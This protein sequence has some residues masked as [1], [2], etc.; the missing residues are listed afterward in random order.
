MT[1]AENACRSC[2][3]SH[4][5]AG[6]E[7]LL[8]FEREE[9]NCLS[10]HDGLV[11]GTNLRAELDKPNAHDPRQYAGVHDP[12]ETPSVATAHV[13]CADCHNPHAVTPE[14]ST[15][16]YIPIG[17][18]LAKV[19]G[20]TIG[21]AYI[22]EAQHEYEVCFRCHADSAVPVTGRIV[23]QAD[24]SNLRLKFSPT[25]PSFHP[26]VSASPSPDTVSLVPGLTSGSLIRCTDCHNNDAG[27]RA[28][29]GGPDGPHGSIYDFLLE[30]NYTVRDDTSE[31]EFEYAICYKCHLRSSI[32]ADQSFKRHRK[33]IEKERSPCSACH[34]PH[35]VT[36]GQGAGSDHTHLINFD[37]RIVRPEPNTGRLEFKDLGS[38]RGSCTL[39]CHGKRHRNQEYHQ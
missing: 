22:G 6:H 1:V 39:L 7:R 19:P 5:A 36:L 8:I 32:L 33:H 31:S 17:A 24:T 23:R 16:G 37:T 21:G 34:D 18:T 4:T 12:V 13:E 2:H 9:D 25:N 38:L 11:A 20:I 3:R 35:G 10:C 27:P 29:G 14:S 26:I 15:S 30:R 28:G